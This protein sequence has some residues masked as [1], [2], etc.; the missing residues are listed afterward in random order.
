MKTSTII[1][2][3]LKELRKYKGITQL[4][5]SEIC[6]VP[7]RTY[8]R[9]EQEKGYNDTLK[10]KYIYKTLSNYQISNK[11]ES[12]PLNIVVVGLGYVGASL[13]ILLSKNNYVTV[14]DIAKD[15]IEKINNR[16]PLFKDSLMKDYLKND[17]LHLSGLEL[18]K[19]IYINKDVVIVATNTDFDVNTNQF[20]TLS[21]ASTIKEVR[22]VNK[23]AL[24]VIKSTV[25]MGFTES[26]NDDNLIFSPEFLKEG[27]ALYDN[28]HPSRII[29]GGNKNNLKVK[30]FA[31]C[32]IDI[33]KTTKRVIYMTS[34]EAEATKLF[35]NAYL[36]MRVAYFN[37][38]DTYAE[39]N[40]L[41]T[42]KIINGIS[43]DPRIGDYYN[44]PSFGYGGYCLPKDTAQ[45]KSSVLNMQNNDLIEAIVSS[46]QTRKEYISKQI[47]GLINSNKKKIIGVYRLSMKTESDNYR[48]A[49]ILDIIYL[50]KEKG[51]KV[52]IYEPN[53]QGD[54]KIDSFSNFCSIS[55]IIVANRMSDE[56]I[57]VASKV[58]TRDLYHEN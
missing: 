27:T 8:K 23:K 29:I 30:K 31:K 22:S 17:K 6:D 49:P 4:E 41:D 24:I 48:N 54:N 9:I 10:Y 55:D 26:F 13:A 47:E 20:N 40:G 33:S 44:N 50:L 57:P 28:L 25:P 1:T 53:Y 56:L 5:A 34:K 18:N 2:M 37:E 15:K 45:L 42:S 12:R 38:L 7:L 39:T 32:L 51:Y 52:V 14:T 43:L 19:D 16:K 46:N 21:V 58:Y 3:K 11:K 35:A 36:A